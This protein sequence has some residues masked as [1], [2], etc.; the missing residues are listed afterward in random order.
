MIYRALRKLRQVLYHTFVEPDIKRSLAECGKASRVESGGDFYPLSNI[1]VG[2]HVSIGAN[3]RFWTTRA[4]IYIEDFALFGPGVTIITGDH[5]KDVAGKHIIELTDDDKTASDDQDVIIGT[6]AW[7]GAGA[8]ILKGVHIGADAIVAAGSVVTKDVPPYTIV[9]GV[10]A[11]FIKERFSEDQLLVHTWQPE[12][13]DVPLPV[14]A[15]GG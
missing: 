8:I 2:D 12:L 11:H 13:D 6:G 3:A 1:H 7:I 14:P 15:K 9:G 10:P 5:R 4:Q